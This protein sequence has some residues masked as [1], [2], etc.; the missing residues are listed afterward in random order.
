MDKF[1]QLMSDAQF[2]LV[3]LANEQTGD[4]KLIESLEVPASTART[5][6]EKGLAFAGVWGLV[7][8][9]PRSAL[10]MPLEGEIVTA[11]TNEFLRRWAHTIRHPRWCMAPALM[12]N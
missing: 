10:A 12:V 5:Y 2:A 1:E 6:T 7:G 9:K 4:W 8:G 3:L 11:I